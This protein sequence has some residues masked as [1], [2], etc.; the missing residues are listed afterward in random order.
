MPQLGLFQ[1]QNI[2]T[3]MVL[4]FKMTYKIKY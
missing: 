3:L 2:N 4:I 1:Q